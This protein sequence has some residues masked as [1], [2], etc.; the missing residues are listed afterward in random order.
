[1]SHLQEWLE[2]TI[3]QLN[4]A[5][6]VG[7]QHPAYD[8]ASQTH[9]GQGQHNRQL[10]SR[11]QH[12][13]GG[14]GEHAMA[15]LAAAC[16]ASCCPPSKNQSDSSALSRAT[17]KR[18]AGARPCPLPLTRPAS[19]SPVDEIRRWSRPVRRPA[20][21]HGP[22]QHPS[23]AEARVVHVNQA[24]V[25]L[26]QCISSQGVCECCCEAAQVSGEGTK[27]A[28]AEGG[29]NAAGITYLKHPGRGSGGGVWCGPG[30]WMGQSMA[31]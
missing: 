12:M 8:A 25:S 24:Q 14:G 4:H 21:S 30:H 23:R 5:A 15:L 19:R 6:E 1:M 18:P 3:T 20:A 9:T 28:K 10:A 13:C 16:Q 22:L 7:S 2:H 27:A 11:H 26:G 31:M 29:L 17:P